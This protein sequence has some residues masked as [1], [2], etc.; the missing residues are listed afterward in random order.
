MVLTSR[1]SSLRCA[2]RACSPAPSI[3]LTLPGTPGT[4]GLTCDTQQIHLGLIDI[5]VLVA[6]L[7]MT[8]GGSRH[9]RLLVRFPASSVRRRTFKF[10]KTTPIYCLCVSVSLNS[11]LCLDTQVSSAFRGSGCSC[12][13][14]LCWFSPLGIRQ[15]CW[16]T[17]SD[18]PN[19]VNDWNTQLRSMSNR[20]K[21]VQ[22]TN[23]GRKQAWS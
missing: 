6:R 5:A 9:F 7:F 20:I 11:D 18:A 3:G 10:T 22:L 1:H 14:V 4:P 21:D 15:R 12:C 13:L 23:S 17:R 2:C 19:N 8:P 16:V